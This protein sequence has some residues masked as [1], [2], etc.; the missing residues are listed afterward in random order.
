MLA[1]LNPGLVWAKAQAEKS[2]SNK[3]DRT[4]KFYYQRPL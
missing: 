4:L 1:M 2:A 3:I